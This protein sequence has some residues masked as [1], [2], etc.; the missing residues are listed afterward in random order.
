MKNQWTNKVTGYLKVKVNGKGTERLLNRLLKQEVH[1]WNA[2]KAGTETLIFCI[3]LEDVPALRKAARNSG[4]KISFLERKGGPFL[5]MKLRKYSG[6]V[7]GLVLFFFIT[8]ILSNMV[9]GIQIKGASPAVEHQ[10]TKELAR[11]NIKVGKLQFTLPGMEDIQKELSNRIPSITWVGVQLQ[12]TT[13][14]FQVVEKKQPKKNS[15]QLH[16]N[17][18][19]S[20]NATIVQTMVEKGQGLVEKHQY[21]SKGQILV[22]GYIGKEGS[23]KFVGAKGKVWAETWYKTKVEVPLKT[24][25]SVFNGDSKVKH[26]ISIG[27]S[28]VPIWGFGK[29]E[30]KEYEEEDDARS[31]HFLKWDLPFQYH[32]KTIM[33]KEIVK[34][35]YTK[36]EAVQQAM[37]M[38]RKDLRKE[39]PEDSKILKENILHNHSDNGKV[40]LTIHYQVLE[41]IAV[42]QPMIQGD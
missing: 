24:S 16:I 30:F 31:F 25:F 35:V 42:G 9:W 20:K 3:R 14:H 37:K 40:E 41:N 36:E 8:F 11:M 21:V 1:I 12:G 32:K 38:A 4:C 18:V 27:K 22:S 6:L 29:N 34:R 23:Q 17:L 5:G 19:S 26:T 15:D 7:V 10:I 2:K 13:F 33:S 28:E 39:T